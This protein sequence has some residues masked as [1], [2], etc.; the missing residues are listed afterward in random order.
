[1]LYARLLYPSYYFD[2]YE[3][4]MNHTEEEEKLIPII[5]LASEYEV[6]LKEAYI[7][8][9]KYAPIEGINWILNKK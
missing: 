4:V 5:D 7:E 9:N 1:M 8:I 3:N 6:F 2:I